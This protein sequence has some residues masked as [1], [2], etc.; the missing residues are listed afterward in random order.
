[1]TGPVPLTTLL[2][3][4]LPESEGLRMMVERVRTEPLPWYVTAG[5]QFVHELFALMQIRLDTTAA[6]G[7]AVY[8]GAELM[9]CLLKCKQ[10]D[11]IDVY[12]FGDNEFIYSVYMLNEQTVG[13]IV[14]RRRHVP[15]SD[16][17]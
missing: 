6:A 1:M 12:H 2:Q 7:T 4:V 3:G 15:G 10:L 9:A 11:E 16:E 8:G 5:T 17:A 14:L 13:G